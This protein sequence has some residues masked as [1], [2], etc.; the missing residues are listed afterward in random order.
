MSLWIYWFD[1]H[2]VLYTHSW[3]QHSFHVWWPMDISFIT[4]KRLMSLVLVEMFELLLGVWHTSLVLIMSATLFWLLPGIW[5]IMRQKKTT[6]IINCYDF[7][8]F[9]C[10]THQ[11]FSHRHRQM[12]SDVISFQHIKEMTSSQ[13][14]AEGFGN[15][16]AKCITAAENE[17]HNN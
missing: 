10:W 3:A 12:I 17:L 11:I 1:S 14:T 7:C 8:M 13:D 5:T 4:T 9:R 16:S 15:S 2:K 6:K